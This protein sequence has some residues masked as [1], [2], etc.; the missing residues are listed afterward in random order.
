VMLAP[1]GD[2]DGDGGSGDDKGVLDALDIIS[3]I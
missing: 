2:G 1:R 3:Q